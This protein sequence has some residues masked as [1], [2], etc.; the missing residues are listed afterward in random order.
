LG[1]LIL[2]GIINVPRFLGVSALL[3]SVVL[4]WQGMSLCFLR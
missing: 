1:F 4:I 2:F 3:I